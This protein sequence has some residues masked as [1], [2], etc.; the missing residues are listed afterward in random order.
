MHKLP[1]ALAG[2]VVVA[3]RAGPP[4][5]DVVGGRLEFA[6]HVGQQIFAVDLGGVGL[7]GRQS[8]SAEVKR[9][10][11]VA[12][13]GPGRDDPRPLHEH[14][15]TDAALERLAFG[16]AQGGV[17][18]AVDS[19]AGGGPA[20]VVG[21]KDQGAVGLAGLFQ[22]GQD[23]TDG[24][25]HGAEH[26]SVGSA[27]GI[28]DGREACLVFLHRLKRGVDGVEGEVEKERL[29]LTAL[30]LNKRRGFLPEGVGE[31]AG[32][33]HRV[34]VAQNRRIVFALAAGFE[35]VFV[36]AAEEPE[37]LVEPAVHRGEPGVG[38][39]MPF[40]NHACFVS[41]GL[42]PFGEGMRLGRERAAEIL[43][44]EAMLVTAADEGCAGGSA[45][46]AVC[47]AVGEPDSGCADPVD[48]GGGN[49][50]AAVAADVGVTHVIGE[51]GHDVRFLGRMEPRLE[52]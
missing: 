24:V 49:V 28:G 21:E 6:G 25:V 11:R 22:G 51:D 27:L 15:D 52:G 47:V 45:E 20:V 29:L 26:G 42:E 43:Y 5:K 14:R 41:G 3:H 44:G 18:G 9:H 32:L 36:A 8:G 50:F 38:A 7:G 39:E 40:A 12:I 13:G 17:H 10:D 48:V 34:V 35:D 30:A 2:A 4:E 37:E 1:V 23:A 46:R 33:V 16:A 19:V 31:I